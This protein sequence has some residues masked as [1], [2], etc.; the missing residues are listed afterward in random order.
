MA[1][2]A[3]RRGDW[4]MTSNGMDV[5]PAVAGDQA[6]TAAVVPLVVTRVVR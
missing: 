5:R 6:K 4:L 3:G 2:Q 1:G